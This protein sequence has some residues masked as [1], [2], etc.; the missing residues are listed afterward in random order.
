MKKIIAYFVSV[1]IG[2]LSLSLLEKTALNNWLARGIG[3]LVAVVM[4]VIM[5]KYYLKESL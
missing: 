1:L 3:A 2:S 4:I 5:Y